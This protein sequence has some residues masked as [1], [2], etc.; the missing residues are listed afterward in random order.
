MRAGRMMS[1]LLLLRNRGKM[2]AARLAAELGVTARTV[3][4]TSRRY[5]N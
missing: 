5:S 1:L 3:P 4:V 2:S